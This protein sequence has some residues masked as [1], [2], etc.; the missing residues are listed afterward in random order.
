[1]SHDSSSPDP[2]QGVFLELAELVNSCPVEQRIFIRSQLGEYTHDLKHLLGLVTAANAVLKRKFA[3]EDDP[4]FREMV[5]MIQ[6]AAQ[7]I[8]AQVDMLTEQFSQYIQ[9]EPD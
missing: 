2:S 1:M 6:E 3:S 7:K 9:T 8:D 5:E 4:Q